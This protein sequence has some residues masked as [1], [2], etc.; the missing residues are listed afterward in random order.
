MK[1][2]FQ[3]TRKSF[4]QLNR[5]CVLIVLVAALQAVDDN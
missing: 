5:R 4:K 3:L 2:M 1:K